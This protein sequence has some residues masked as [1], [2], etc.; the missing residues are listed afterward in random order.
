MGQL[1]VE[2]DYMP[3]DEAIKLKYLL[4]SLDD[5]YFIDRRTIKRNYGVDGEDYAKHHSVAGV[6][7]P[8]DIASIIERFKPIIEPFECEEYLVNRYYEGDYIPPHIDNEGYFRVANILLTDTEE[9]FAYY[10]EGLE[11]SRSILPDSIG[12][13]VIIEDVGLLHEVLPVLNTRHIV[14]YLYR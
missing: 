7:L 11:R 12:T 14:S 10:P 6:Q 9:V 8:K 1:N 2:L 13:L 4:E 3:R 5:S